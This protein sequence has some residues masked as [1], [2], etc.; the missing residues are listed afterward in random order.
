MNPIQLFT[1]VD[2]R[3]PRQTYWLGIVAITVLGLP[4]IAL[5]A[6]LGGGTA[7]AI[8]NLFFLWCGF[9]LSAKRAQDRGKHYLFVAAYFALLAIVTNLSASQSKMMGKMAAEPSPLL[10][11]VSLLFIAYVIFLFIELGLRRGTIGPNRYGPDPIEN[12]AQTQGQ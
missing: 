1:N 10:I 9:A 5:A 12:A 8:A 6:Y 7:G 3:I 2:G 4:S 11:V